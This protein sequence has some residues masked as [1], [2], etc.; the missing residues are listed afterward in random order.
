VTLRGLMLEMFFPSPKLTL[1]E[2][3]W[4]TMGAKCSMVQ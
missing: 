3:K 2:M 1:Q 4:K